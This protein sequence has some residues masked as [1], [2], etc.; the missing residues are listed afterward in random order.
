MT[1]PSRGV[2][3]IVVS[4]DRP[5]CA[6]HSEAPL[7]RWQLTTRR[8]S[9]SA[10]NQPRGAAD[11]VC[12]RQSVEAVAADGPPLPPFRRERVGRRLARHRRVERRVEARDLDRLGE[13]RRGR[14]DPVQAALLVQRRERPER[15]ER[16]LDS[17][18]D[19]H[20]PDEL[21]A[22]VDHAVPDDIRGSVL[23]DEC[24]QRLPHVRTCPSLDLGTAEQRVVGVEQREFQTARAC[25][26]D[27]YAHH[28]S[29]TAPRTLLRF[30]LFMV[31][32]SSPE[33]QRNLRRTHASGPS[34][35]LGERR[36]TVVGDDN[37]ASNSPSSTEH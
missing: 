19:H 28:C 2:N 29:A 26:H 16:A 9:A 24:P 23:G 31:T 15:F 4:S 35:A 34:A 18:V 36:I 20:W 10:S 21:L 6:A 30:G 14:P 27:E 25:V 33:S 12:M 13:H 37:S 5:P 3:P 11:G 8:L 22:P 7:P 17:L 32:T 1:R